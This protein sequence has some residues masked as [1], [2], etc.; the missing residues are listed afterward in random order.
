MVWHEDKERLT[1]IDF[2]YSN[3]NYKGYDIAHYVNEGFMD[4]TYP[5]RPKF[6]IYENQM[7]EYLKESLLPESE[8]EKVLICYLERYHEVIEEHP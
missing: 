8:M 6:K 7:L 5:V 2:E 4:Y 1:M 3:L